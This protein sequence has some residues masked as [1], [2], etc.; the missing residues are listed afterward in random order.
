VSDLRLELD[1]F[2]AAE[3]RRTVIEELEARV[4]TLSRFKRPTKKHY[5]KAKLFAGRVCAVVM[6]E[7]SNLKRFSELV[8]KPVCVEGHILTEFGNVAKVHFKER[9]LECWFLKKLLGNQKYV[10]HAEPYV[11]GV[12]SAGIVFEKNAENILKDHKRLEALLE[13]NS[14]KLTYYRI[15]DVFESRGRKIV[16]LECRHFPMGFSSKVRIFRTFEQRKTA[17]L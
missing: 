11:R 8:N 14:S 16:M 12:Q 5:E 7:Y 17:E 10:R 3:F 13:L 9:F 15:F 6:G 1:E 4:P 2:D